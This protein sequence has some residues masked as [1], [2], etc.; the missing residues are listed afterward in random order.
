[1]AFPLI[2]LAASFLPEIV[3]LIA[4]DR[5]GQATTAVTEAVR[6]VTGTDDPVAAKAR[7]DGD[8]QLA[9]NLRTRLA[10]IAVEQEKVRLEAEERRRQ[11]ELAE[12]EKRLTDVQGARASMLQLSANQDPMRWGASIVSTVVTLMFILALLIFTLPSV[13][14]IDD[15]NREL[16]NI[17]LGALVA[18]FTAVINFW[19]G[20]SQ[21]SRD[22]DSTVRALQASQSQQATAALANQTQNTQSAIQGLKQAAEAASTS[23]ANAATTAAP[24]AS[25][26]A[27]AAAVKRQAF[28]TAIRLV[29]E[30]EGGFSN[31]PRDKGGPT[32]FGITFKTYAAFFDL[33]PATVTEQMMRDLHRDVAI[34]IYRTSYWGA[35]RCDALP[36]GVDLSVFDFG[37]NAGVRTA[38]RKLQEVVGVK[39]DGSI[40][41]ITLAAIEACGVASAIGRFAERRLD[42]YRSLD[43]FAVFGKGWTT[44]TNDIREAAL[45]L[46]REATG[47]A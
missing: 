28:D 26:A 7:L 8:P 10:E 3:R 47:A 30:Q 45:R 36:P 24:G 29:L 40:G 18:S 16:V 6:I 13:F 14:S 41:P 11:T 42:Y 33:D 1:M 17:V 4:G 2:A 22:K 46:S 19:I 15:R 32:N 25:R 9:A 23:A 39:V 27:P 38:V 12:L 5:A 31:H 20:S 35:A 44:R 43:D 37:V 21:G 34:E